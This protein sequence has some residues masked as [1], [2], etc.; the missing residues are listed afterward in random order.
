VGYGTPAAGPVPPE[1]PL[2]LAGGPAED[3]K[4]ADSLLSAAG[5]R[6]EGIG[7]R[8]R[9]G[10]D[11]DVELLTVGSGDN[12]VEQLV[13]A[14]LGALGFRV[15][16]RQLEMG[17]FLTRA[18]GQ[19]KEFDMLV[20]GIPGDLSLSFLGSMFDSR[21]RGSALDYADYHTPEIDSLLGRARRAGVDD[22]PAAWRGVQEALN[23]DM[24]I[25][26][27]YHSRGLQGVTRRLFG[28]T[29]DLRG[30]LES[31]ARWYVPDSH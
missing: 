1:S 25:A 2:A 14:D 7:T 15:V 29:F 31:V 23:R 20:T 5:W 9:G 17:A 4:L 3:P 27:I 19:P 30:E 11:L 22:L 24:P 26:W 13:Q 8:R 10:K 21:Q 18:R 16:I 6:R 28:V 12:A